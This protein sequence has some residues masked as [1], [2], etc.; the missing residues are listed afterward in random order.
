M[1]ALSIAVT[2]RE[3]DDQVAIPVPDQPLEL[4]LEG[5]GGAATHERLPR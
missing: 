3:I 4:L 1:P 2:S 5:L